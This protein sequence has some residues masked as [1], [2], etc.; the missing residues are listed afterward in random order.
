MRQSLKERRRRREILAI[1]IK[2]I[3]MELIR[4]FVSKQILRYFAIKTVNTLNALSAAQ[5][6]IKNRIIAG[7]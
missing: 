3:N 6:P 4:S 1:T 5:Q 7:I 2:I